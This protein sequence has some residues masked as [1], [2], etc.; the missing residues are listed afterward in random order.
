M[1]RTEL[2]LLLANFGYNP[3]TLK[4]LSNKELAR[5]TILTLA[6]KWFEI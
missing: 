6:V 3:K 4:I 2:I 5:V 1:T